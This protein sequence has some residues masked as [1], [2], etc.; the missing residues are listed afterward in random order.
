[1]NLVKRIAG[2]FVELIGLLCLGIAF[3]INVI[4]A[5]AF[6]VLLPNLPL[7]IIG[8]LVFAAVWGWG[9]GQGAVI[10]ILATPIAL[11]LYG[12]GWD[13]LLV[14]WPMALVGGLILR[15][16]SETRYSTM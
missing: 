8:Y 15:F 12:A 7:T 4:L 3:L 5:A 16:C 1:M 10:I 2:E 13:M 6:P 14:T 11:G 9:F